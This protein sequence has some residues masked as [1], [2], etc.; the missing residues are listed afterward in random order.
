MPSPCELK[1]L[2][3]KKYL[4]N[5]DDVKRLKEIGITPISND[6]SEYG[7]PIDRYY[8]EKFIYENRKYIHG[9]VMEVQDNRYT[10]KF[11]LNNVAS[12]YICH[13]EG[14]NGALK[15]NFE[16]GEGIKKESIDCMICTQTLQY[17]YHVET[18]VNNIFTMLKKGGSALITVP[19]IKPISIF[20]N[21]NWGEYWS[22]TEKSIKK[23][24]ENIG[25]KC[26]YET[27]VYGNAKTATALLYGICAEEFS[28]YDLDYADSRYPFIIG[29]R[30]SK[31]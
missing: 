5:N 1:E 2:I 8:I 4:D 29:L 7:M 16:N 24:C 9:T 11:G 3:R 28:T 15:I 25:Q 12:S 22:F 30:L 26:D 31:C 10:S 13:V 23:I 19:G 14:W 18:A 21:E 20:H 27:K 6:G 17:I